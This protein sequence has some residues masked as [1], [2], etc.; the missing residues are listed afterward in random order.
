MHYG[1]HTSLYWN[2]VPVFLYPLT[3][4][5]FTTYAVLFDLAVRGG[6]AARAPA[7]R[8]RWWSSSL[9][10]A[11]LETGLNANPSMRATF[12]YGDLGL[13]AHVRHADVR[14]A[15]RHRGPA[16]EAHRRA[17]AA[18]TPPPR[19]RRRGLAA[20]MIILCVDEV[21]ARAG[22]AAL[23]DRG[24]RAAWASRASRGPSCLAAP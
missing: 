16:V 21:W 2:D 13:R 19:G 12:C 9:L 8:P 11:F 4:V 20:M 14:L 5:Y 24:R 22:R 1:F 15:L 17:A 6:G 23:H 10:L 7:R 18:T 3:A